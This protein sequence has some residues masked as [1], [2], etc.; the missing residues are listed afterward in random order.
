MFPLIRV[1]DLAI[2]GGITGIYGY[3]RD[4]NIL[5]DPMEFAKVYATTYGAILVGHIIMDYFG[6]SKVVGA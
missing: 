2:A 6:V 5:R 4:G 3:F 1:R